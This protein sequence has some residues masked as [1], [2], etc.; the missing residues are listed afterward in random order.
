MTFM[1]VFSS[2]FVGKSILGWRMFVLICQIDCDN[3][4]DFVGFLFCGSF[5][6]LSQSWI[7]EHSTPKLG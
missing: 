1:H 6:V 5:A 7:A 3:Y 2:I 4:A